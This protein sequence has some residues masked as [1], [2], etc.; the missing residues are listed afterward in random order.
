MLVLLYSFFLLEFLL[1]FTVSH[2]Y[3]HSSLKVWRHVVHGPV[4]MSSIALNWRCCLW[5]LSRYDSIYITE[6]E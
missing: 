2:F 1:F 4:L 6:N 3:F 5:S